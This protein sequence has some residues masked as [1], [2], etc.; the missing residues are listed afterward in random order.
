MS[1][2][3][4]KAFISKECVACGSCL[5]ACPQNAI[6]IYKGIRAILDENKCLGCGKCAKICPASVISI[7]S[8]GGAQ[9][10]EKTQV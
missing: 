6:I 3:K 8:R 1:V 5:K 2:G 9:N 7:V 10:A 4:H